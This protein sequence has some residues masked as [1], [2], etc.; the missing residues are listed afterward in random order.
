MF[1]LNT[2]DNLDDIIQAI[3]NMPYDDGKTN[4]TGALR[5][6]RLNVF[7]ESAGDRPTVPNVL[8]LISDG[9]PN[10]EETGTQQEGEVVRNQGITL[11]PVGITSAIDKKLMNGLA[12]SG[13]AIESP[14]FQTLDLMKVV[15][16]LAKVLC[17]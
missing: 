12:S 11:V 8:V 9:T 13:N 1:T 5:E 2:Y 7:K 17:N 3:R 16:N 14:T 15:S 10:V 6:T 4:I